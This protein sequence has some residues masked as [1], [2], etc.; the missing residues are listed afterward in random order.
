MRLFL[1]MASALYSVSLLA[2]VPGSH[3]LDELPR[4]PR[5]EIVDF[6]HQAS[7]E[8]LYPQSSISRIS[9]R[10]RYERAVTAQGDLTRVT[11]RLPTEGASKEAFTAARLAL[12]EQGAHLLY[13]CEARDCG[14]SSLW[15]N[16]VFGNATL[17]GPDGQQ[18]YALLRLAEPKEDSLI[19]LYAITRGNRRA[20]LH[21]ERL[22]AQAELG[23]LL[24]TPATLQLQLR[25]VGELDLG[26]LEGE[27]N[28][29]W[30]EV[31]V[32]MLN[33]D[34]TARVRLSGSNSAA[35]RDALVARGVLTTRLEVGKTSGDGLHVELLR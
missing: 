6:T 32:R 29:T 24:P 12:M 34:S 18:A 19:A 27:P 10:L 13:W 20:Y 5:A 35:W 28:Q 17:Y 8:R 2:D 23:V 15:A 26:L 3:D 30:V 9:G 31:L 7:E 16:S 33:L 14:S 21:A 25:E 22:D 11:Y 1:V 4:Y